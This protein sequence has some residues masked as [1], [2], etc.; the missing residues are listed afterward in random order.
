MTFNKTRECIR[1]Q[2]RA[3]EGRACPPTK[4]KLQ[5][6]EQAR[7]GLAAAAADA[8]FIADK[9]PA[10][11]FVMLP[12]NA[13]SAVAKCA[14]HCELLVHSSSMDRSAGSTASTFSP[15]V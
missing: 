7:V 4:P 8:Q 14:R 12:S 9:E 10:A 1:G 6:V 2:L 3:P 11:N 5:H 13:V 15:L